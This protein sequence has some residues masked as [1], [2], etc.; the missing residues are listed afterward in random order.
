MLQYLLPT[1]S[2]QTTDNVDAEFAKK[3]IVLSYA[4]QGGQER[5][6]YLLEI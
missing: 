1:V 5:V 4:P 6:Q 3:Y 2:V